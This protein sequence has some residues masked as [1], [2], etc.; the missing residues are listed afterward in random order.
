MLRVRGEKGSGPRPWCRG[1]QWITNQAGTFNVLNGAGAGAMKLM[2]AKMMV[3]G[4]G[5]GAAGLSFVLMCCQGAAEVRYKLLHSASLLLA[6]VAR[7]VP[8]CLQ[9]RL[10]G[11]RRRHKVVTSGIHDHG[12]SCRLCTAFHAHSVS[13]DNVPLGY[14]LA[15]FAYAHDRR[16][17][18]T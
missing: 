2:S 8:G 14:L 3:R 10:R 18:L 16:E 6:V 9:V 7:D 4:L 12:R 15:D 11:S 1:A 5:L 17:G 13:I